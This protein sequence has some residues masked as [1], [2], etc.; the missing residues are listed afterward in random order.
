MS[1]TLANVVEEISPPPDNLPA[2][3]LIHGPLLPQLIRLALPT[4]AVLFMT[5]LLSVAETYFVSALGLNAIAAASLVV[6]ALLLMTTVASAGIGGG[7]SSAI[8]RAIG[9]RR[10]D[11]A[12]SLAGMR[13]SSAE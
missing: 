9:A 12:E 4:A 5:T 13:W 3:K 6:P 1:A 7:V 10:Q 11:E 8:A 2:N